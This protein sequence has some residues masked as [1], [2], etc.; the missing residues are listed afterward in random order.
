MPRNKKAVVELTSVRGQTKRIMVEPANQ[1][2]LQVEAF[3]QWVQGDRAAGE[4]FGDGLMN[5][6]IM[7]AIRLSAESA[8]EIQ[9]T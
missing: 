4:R 9:L 3:S 5:A 8:R 1:F 7:D 6:K 2:A